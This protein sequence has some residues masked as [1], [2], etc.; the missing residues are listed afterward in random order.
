[1]YHSNLERTVDNLGYNPLDNTFRDFLY[2]P[3]PQPYASFVRSTVLT[4]AL[5]SSDLSEPEAVEVIFDFMNVHLDYM[6]SRFRSMTEKL[7]KSLAR[8]DDLDKFK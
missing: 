7:E 6:H 2:T 5:S 4:P 3:R 1:M 8:M